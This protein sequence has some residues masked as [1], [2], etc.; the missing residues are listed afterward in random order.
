MDETKNPT[1]E[2]LTERLSAL[3]RDLAAAPTHPRAALGIRG[4]TPL[5]SMILTSPPHETSPVKNPIILTIPG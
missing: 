5:L 2:E 1:L 4:C 3:V